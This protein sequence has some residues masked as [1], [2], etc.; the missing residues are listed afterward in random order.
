MRRNAAFWRPFFGGSRKQV[1]RAP[2]V[3]RYCQLLATTYFPKLLKADAY[4]VFD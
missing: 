2:L 1:E 4:F 3:S